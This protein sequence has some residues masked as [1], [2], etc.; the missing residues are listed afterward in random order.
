MSIGRIYHPF[1]DWEE[2]KQGLWRSVESKH[3]KMLL[4]WAIEFTGNHKK[5]GAWMRKVLQ[6]WII[7]CEHNLSDRAQNRRA[8][9]G[10][11]AVC[12]A[13]DIPEDITR[14]AWGNLTQKQ[15]DLADKQAD[16]A[17]EE[18]E[19]VYERKN[20]AVHN[21]M[22]FPGVSVRHT[23]RGSS[24]A[25]KPKQSAIVS[26]HLSSYPEKRSAPDISGVL[27]A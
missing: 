13:L 15:R 22:A 25:R 10:H 5:Y 27:E 6:E 3:R 19:E 14:E 24:K 17:I 20:R 16:F 21:Q 26:K 7:S 4:E 9:I 11:A 18:W 2:T 12:L 23:R 8:W 1:F